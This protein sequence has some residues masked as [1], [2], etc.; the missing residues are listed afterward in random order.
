MGKSI[1]I[2]YL[3]VSSAIKLIRNE[4]GANVTAL[5][6]PQSLA[7]EFLLIKVIG[8][9]KIKYTL[10]KMSSSKLS[11]NIAGDIFYRTKDIASEI[12][13]EYIYIEST[14]VNECLNFN[15]KTWLFHS[16]WRQVSIIEYV[17]KLN[18]NF[19]VIY[20]STQVSTK[21]L[22]KS[23][24]YQSELNKEWLIHYKSSFLIDDNGFSYE[25]RRPIIK[26]VGKKI[27][28]LFEVL[29]SLFFVKFRMKLP[30]T[31]IDLLIFSHSSQKWLNLDQINDD[32]T[33]NSKIVYP[34]GIVGSDKDAFNIKS[35]FWSDIFAFYLHMGTGVLNFFWAISININLFSDLLA[36]WKFVYI[37]ESLFDKYDVKIVL[38]GFESPIATMA[39]SIASDN[40]EMMSCDCIW[41]IGEAPMEFAPTQHKFSDRFFLWGKWHHDLMSAS[42][43]K[44]SGHIIVGYVGDN[45]IPLMKNE[46]E[47]FRENQLNKFNKIITVFDSGAS[48]D[49]HFPEEI[50]I[51]YV[52]NIIII[53]EEFNALVVLKIKKGD[54]RYENIIKLNNNVRLIIHYEK[55]SL[56]AA[57]NSDV[58]IGVASSSPASISAVHGLQAILY[59]PNKMVWDKWESYENSCVITRSISDLKKILIES[60]SYDISKKTTSPS[61]IDPFADGKAQQRMENYIQNVFDNL[62]LGKNEAMQL[63]DDKYKKLWGDDKVIVNKNLNKGLNEKNKI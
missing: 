44:S 5:F 63:A 4:R 54:K 7:M 12:S 33:L 11:D 51:E 38:S 57:L 52:K 3:N 53:A 29:H 27:S 23:I 60:L 39:T 58:V 50:Y 36:R 61:Y 24:L 16:L 6:R 37:L 31:K 25:R 10:D 48:E 62:H 46:G 45:Y 1:I 9:F 56:V 42:L 26:Y 22:M 40:L 32:A 47:N 8:L 43:D 14:K 21:L 17:K 41:S 2:D 15:I 59:D 18:V 28:S 49:G 13:K 34:N 35:I 20:I 55:A 30:D 19:E